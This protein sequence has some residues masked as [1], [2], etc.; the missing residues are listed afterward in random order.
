VTAGENEQKQV[1]TPE[2]LEQDSRK[3]PRKNFFVRLAEKLWLRPGIGEAKRV[4]RPSSGTSHLPPA[5]RSTTT[6]PGDHIIGDDVA[7]PLAEDVRT[8]SPRKLTF[9]E[10]VRIKVK[11]SPPPDG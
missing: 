9:R 4:A 8:R 2:E 7:T 5:S 10:G 1:P 3:A 11:E 6:P